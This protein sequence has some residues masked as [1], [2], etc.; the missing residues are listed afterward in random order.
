MN[1]SLPTRRLPARPDAEQL[2][3]QAKD[4][5]KNF[6]AGDAE[7][8]AEVRKHYRD[9][10][11][12]TFA[13]H[14][15]QL[16]IARAYG[17]ES[18]PKLKAYVDGVN[19]HLLTNAVRAGN[20]DEVRS[21]LRVRP[22]LVNVVIAWNN[23]HTALHYAVL[24]RMPEMVRVLMQNGANARAGISPRNEATTAIAIATE[25]GYDEIAGI[26]REEE[27][28]RVDPVPQ[29]EYPRARDAHEPTRE[30]VKNGNVEFLLALH[31]EGRLVA[32]QDDD[33]WLLKVAARYDRPDMLELLLDWG[34]DPDA[35]VR[36]ESEGVE[37]IAFSW[38]M[39]LYEC[40]RY[41]KHTMAEMLLKR[42]ADP[43][44]RVYA[45]GTPLSEAFGRQ[46]ERM[47][48]LLESYGGQPNPSMAGLYRR[49]D[50][51]IRMLEKYGDA[52]L[53]DDGFGGGKVAEQL[54]AA[55][56][57]GGDAEIL[58]L[59]LERVD[60]PAGDPRWNGLLSAPLGFWNHWIGP[61]CHPE[62][63][64]TTYLS[65]FRMILEQTGPPNGRLRF[66]TTI[67]HE[68]VTMA[69]HTTAEERVAFAEAALD[70]GARMDMRDDLLEST[71]LGWA[72]RWGR[73]ELV[74]LFLVRGAPVVEPD[75]EPWAQP[76][77][78]ARKKDHTEISALLEGGAR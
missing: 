16:V 70:A 37:E 41:G 33:G 22:E 9:V 66:G 20:V 71:P 78:W 11:A 7:G 26:I 15:A 55:A 2:K 63:D 77:A 46:D 25:R 8:V 34:L 18:W 27:A 35:K 28:R 43:N 30:A 3:H 57:R 47:I 60:I 39:P 62:W 45:S 76:R 42:G 68:I 32:P 36:V 59:A 54:V 17:F 4:L 10:A 67:L 19:V 50:L 73:V 44:G 31:A 49:K 72:C 13:L 58:K 65:C 38:G 56:A 48:A 21:I 24:Q 51:A 52:V 14:D 53:P 23:E 40:A 1:R 5:L 69:D 61:W 29:P 64:R 75:A 12:G 74:K 6:A